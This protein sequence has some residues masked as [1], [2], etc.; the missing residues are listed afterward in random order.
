MVHWVEGRS[1]SRNDIYVSEP[2]RWTR[3]KPA[4]PWPE[5][6][7]GFVFEKIYPCRPWYP[8]KIL[9]HMSF[10]YWTARLTTAGTYIRAMDA[11][12]KTLPHEEGTWSGKFSPLHLSKPWTLNLELLKDH[13]MCHLFITFLPE[14]PRPVLCVASEH[15]CWFHGERHRSWFPWPWS[16]GVWVQRGLRPPAHT[17]YR[18]CSRSCIQ[19][20]IVSTALGSKV[21]FLYFII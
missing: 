17:H 6:P 16:W 2:Y 11:I 21:Y 14:T 3:G 10:V 5:D 13:L 4:I 7:S 15:W 20:C 9:L 1:L 8:N 18:V 12:T 19:Y